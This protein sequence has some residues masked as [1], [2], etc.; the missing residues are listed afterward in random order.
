[1]ITVA[2]AQTNLLNYVNHAIPTDMREVYDVLVVEKMK[3][4]RFF[5]EF[6]EET[7]SE[8]NESNTFDSPAWVTYKQKL[9]EYANI[10]SFLNQSKYY[11]NKNVR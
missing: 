5:S 11:L 9:K 6:L 10:E 3:M 2:E 1:M 8:M 7:E 4:D